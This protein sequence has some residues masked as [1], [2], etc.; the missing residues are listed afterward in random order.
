M[1]W[2]KFM[3]IIMAL[4]LITTALAACNPTGT[5]TPTTEAPQS[6]TITA[7]AGANGSI[8]PAGSVTVNSG[9]SPTF[10]VTPDTGYK[11]A[12]VVIDDESQG[13]LSSVT[14]SDVNDD[15]T[16]T[17]T[18]EAIPIESLGD[19][20][21]G[22]A[23]SIEQQSSGEPVADVVTDVNGVFSFDITPVLGMVEPDADTMILNL[24]VTPPEGEQYQLPEGASNIV[25]IVINLDEGPIYTFVLYLEPGA[26]GFAVGAFSVG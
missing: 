9:D 21:P 13:P 18:F 17:V 3:A 12:D 1:K 25:A 15:H 2:Y 11:I 16:V 7:T 20:V 23:I 26:T 19:P 10:T 4:A 24:Y 6:F 5:T 14:F 22:A 8:D